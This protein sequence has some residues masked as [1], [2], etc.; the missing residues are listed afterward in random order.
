MSTTQITPS[1]G[2]VKITMATI[3]VDILTCTTGGHNK[4]WVLFESFDKDTW[5]MTYYGS[6]GKKG[7]TTVRQ[8]E[9]V[10]NYGKKLLNQKVLDKDYQRKGTLSFRIPMSIMERM[11][12]TNLATGNGGVSKDATEILLQVFFN[13][14]HKKFKTAP[15]CGS[16]KRSFLTEG[17]NLLKAAYIEFLEMDAL[18]KKAYKEDVEFWQTWATLVED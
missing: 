3:N 8:E 11:T 17:D 12:S 7:K 5:Y 15:P 14:Y 4:Y 2:E 18:D 6:I 16:V 10:Y 9:Y 13:E 1:S